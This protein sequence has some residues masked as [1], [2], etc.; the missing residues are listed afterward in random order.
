MMD[1]NEKIRI[2]KIILRWADEVRGEYKRNLNRIN[3][4]TA[5]FLNVGVEGFVDI[6][7][8]EGSIVIHGLEGKE[9]E[10][11]LMDELKELK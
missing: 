11:Y 6:N 1:K 5:E 8:R 10:T 3:K 9:K 4:E 7:Y 2:L